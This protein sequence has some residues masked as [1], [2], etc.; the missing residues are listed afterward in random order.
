MIDVREQ[1][2]LLA[3]DFDWLLVEGPKVLYKYSWEDREKNERAFGV[4]RAPSIFTAFSS[5]VS[6]TSNF[7]DKDLKKVTVFYGAVTIYFDGLE[8]CVSKSTD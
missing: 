1:F 2:M 8:L 3:K 7:R 4:V 6:S 5:I